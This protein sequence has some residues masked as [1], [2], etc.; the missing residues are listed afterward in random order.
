[1]IGLACAITM[2]VSGV[3]FELIDKE[4]LSMINWEKFLA[5][6]LGILFCTLMVVGW[7]VTNYYNNKYE[8]VG[9]IKFGEEETIITEDLQ[10]LRLV[11]AEYGIILKG[12]GY[13]GM[14]EGVPWSKAYAMSISSGIYEVTFANGENCHNYEILVEYEKQLEVLNNLLQTFKKTT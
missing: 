8:I 7:I 1:M 10:C 4:P 13:Q 5:R 11:N 3:V 9:R 12:S 2:I 6:P 14:N